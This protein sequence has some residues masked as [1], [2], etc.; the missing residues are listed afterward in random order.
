MSIFR[1]KSSKKGKKNLSDKSADKPVRTNKYW[2]LFGTLGLAFSTL[3][4]GCAIG[5][6]TEEK[7]KKIVVDYL[8]EPVRMA[9]DSI[10]FHLE[11]FDHHPDINLTVNGREIGVEQTGDD[12]QMTYRAVFPI[13]PDDS[14]VV[15][16]E[17]SA[18][19]VSVDTS[20]ES[21]DYESSV[22]G[23]L[24][25][26]EFDTVVLGDYNYLL[27]LDAVDT[28]ES[29]ASFT[30]LNEAGMEINT[31]TVPV[32]GLH[33]FHTDYETGYQYVIH[34]K[35]VREDGVEFAIKEQRD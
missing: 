18:E 25:I 4:T 28:V 26:G 34:V 1:F 7:E 19:E 9:P 20:F 16:V 30:L 14:G 12:G 6:G 21:F 33:L 11:N 23:S 5:I 3:F 24:N 10:L 17:I 22:S 31:F 13:L 32:G 2:R 15:N 8:P 29:T 27:R 35:D